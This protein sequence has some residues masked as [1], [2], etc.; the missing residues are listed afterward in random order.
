MGAWLEFKND[1]GPSRCFAPSGHALSGRT[2]QRLT[3]S[4]SEKVQKII[5]F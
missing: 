5:I 3:G 1:K 4:D 2:N